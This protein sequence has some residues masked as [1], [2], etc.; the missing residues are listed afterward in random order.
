MDQSDL[1]H[2]VVIAVSFCMLINYSTSLS[3]G[4]F[5]KPMTLEIKSHV[6]WATYCNK[7]LILVNMHGLML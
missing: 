5:W 1:R 6:T 4:V 3:F 2:S 7:Y